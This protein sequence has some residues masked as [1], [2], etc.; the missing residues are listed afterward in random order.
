MRII[1]RQTLVFSVA[2]LL[3][4]CYEPDR[5]CEK[6]VEGTF[7]SQVSIDDIVYKSKFKR[8][9]N[10]QTETFKNVTDSAS[11]RWINPCEYILKTVNP[12]SKN[13]EKPIHIKILTTT[14]DSYTFE[15]N[16]VGEMLKQTGTAT[17]IE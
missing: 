14:K 10:L 4:G 11:V 9:N 17:K 6:F 1:V 5:D 13:A 3:S 2:F 15:Y 12:K 7:V 8:H 16:F